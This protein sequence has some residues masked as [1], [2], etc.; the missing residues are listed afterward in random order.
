MAHY[1]HVTADERQL[2]ADLLMLQYSKA[3]IGRWLKRARST[4][5]RELQRNQG[6]AGY[7]PA[8]AQQQATARHTHRRCK[9]K[10]RCL[11]REV[12]RR[13]KLRWSPDQIAGR[14]RREFYDIPRRRISS[15]TIYTWLKTPS[16]R[17]Y[18]VYLRFYR[19][20]PRP[21]RHVAEHRLFANRPAV[22]N[23][24]ERYGDWEADTI[25]GPRGA[26]DKPVLYNLTERA[27]GFTELA[28]GANRAS[29]TANRIVKNRLKHQPPGWALSVTT[30]N[31][32]EF[33]RL[34]ELE[35]LLHLTTYLADPY[36]SWQRGTVE[37]TNGLIRQFFPKGTN[38]RKV[39][40]KRVRMVQNLLNNRPRKRLGY[41]TPQ[42]IRTKH[43]SDAL[44][45]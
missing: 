23:H 14:A 16:G 11:A 45:S 17:P 33:A 9:M 19:V 4:V 29:E 44:Q 7:V 20:K 22:I 42:E 27:S 28:W 34:R 26:R 21:A 1:R 10:Q 40:P 13:L 41:Q 5:F 8:E 6:A 15:Q 31:G 32:K 39:H 43:A 24:R 35:R 36:K 3:A 12:K 25:V 18:R 37:N 30:D 38:F 2:L